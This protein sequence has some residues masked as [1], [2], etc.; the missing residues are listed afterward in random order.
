MSATTNDSQIAVV[1]HGP[2][3]LKIEQRPRLAP[4]SGQCQV[5]I[6]ATGLCGSDL[7]YY[8]HGRNG[9][10]ALR[11]PL[12]LGHEASGIITAIGPDVD[13]SL[14]LKVGDRVAIEC[15]IACGRNHS[16]HAPHRSGRYNLCGQMRF[17]SSAKTWPHLDG[18]LQTT[19]NHPAHLLHLLPDT[20]TYEQAALAEPL[21]VVLHAARR[22]GLISAL[23]VLVIGAGAIGFLAAALARTLSDR[24]ESIADVATIA[25]MDI[26]ATKLGALKNAGFADVTFTVPLGPRP[27]TKEEGLKNS[28]DL[29]DL[30]LEELAKAAGYDLVF[31]CTGVESCIQ[32][33]IYMART[34]GKVALVGMGTP[35]PMIPLGA[36][37]LREIDLI[38]VFRYEHTYPEALRLLASKTMANLESVM[39]TQRFPLEQTSDAFKVI[40]SG[41]GEGGAMVLKVMVGPKY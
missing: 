2:K 19:M 41:K 16:T 23:R 28:H 6:Q 17:C 21:S 4:G 10:F 9:D 5:E 32:T 33:A 13:P 26:D 30:A 7:H 27:Q 25:A 24:G 1:L 22:V 34:G 37:A 11:D 40:E 20:C 14:N 18:S 8:K 35:N 3:D 12:V 36:A 38:G 39:V 15:G 31:E 29:A